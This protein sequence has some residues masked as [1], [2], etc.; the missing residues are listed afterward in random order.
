MIIAEPNPFVLFA[1]FPCPASSIGW[2]NALKGQFAQS[3]QRERR[4]GKRWYE[5][6]FDVKTEPL[7]QIAWEVIEGRCWAFHSQQQ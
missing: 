7:V 5:D 6:F 2:T 1:A 3:P 4:E